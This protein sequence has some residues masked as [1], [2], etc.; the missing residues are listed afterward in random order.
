MS[1]EEKDESLDSGNMAPSPS[2]GAG[3]DDPA[4]LVMEPPPPLAYEQPRF[5]PRECFMVHHRAVRDG[6]AHHPYPGFLAFV[7]D[8]ERLE[9]M[10]IAASEEL[11]RAA[12]IGRHSRATL[13]LPRDHASAALRHLALI[14][15][16]EQARPVARLLDLQTEVG[17]ADPLG[18]RFEAI[19]TDGPTFFSAGGAV[20]M[21]FPTGP[22]LRMLEDA[23]ASWAAI[24]PRR[25]FE[26]RSNR[27]RTGG[28]PPSAGQQETL[29]RAEHGPRGCRSRLC[30]HTEIPV[31]IATV[32]AGGEETHVRISG[33]ALD[34][35]FLI[36]RYDRCEVGGPEADESLSRVH[37][38]VIREGRKVIAIDTASTNGTYSG[39]DRVHLIELQERT[40]LD[41]G[42]VLEFTWR[43]CN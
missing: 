32:S 41:L 11:A 15:R 27:H 33:R 4:T 3:L 16:L 22:S 10:W 12:I 43:T 38:L 2:L 34:E 19:R 18:R 9:A 25:W 31:G 5:D 36:G 37:L 23:D 35:G 8:G 21:L 20:L 29:V 1:G 26:S 6:L 40:R 39:E 7:A 42:G 17:F 14:V 30:R 13:A 28:P 24:P